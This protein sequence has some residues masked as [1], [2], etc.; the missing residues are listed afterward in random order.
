MQFTRSSLADALGFAHKVWSG[1]ELWSPRVLQDGLAIPPVERIL[2]YGNCVAGL[3]LEAEAEIARI[4]HI[5][6][7]AW[8]GLLQTVARDNAERAPAVSATAI[9]SLN[10]AI[11]VTNRLFRLQNIGEKFLNSMRNNLE[12][13]DDVS[14]SKKAKVTRG[15]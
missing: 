5:M 7:E 12:S 8:Y 15:N 4:A 2:T 1:T 9:D 14:E 6:D 13:T 3:L 11:W 10:P